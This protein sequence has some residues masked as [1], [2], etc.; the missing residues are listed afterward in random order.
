MRTPIERG[1][2]CRAVVHRPSMGGTP[3]DACPCN[4]SRWWHG[5]PEDDPFEQP[6][7]PPPT[8]DSI[9]AAAVVQSWW[10]NHLARWDD[11]DD[12]VTRVLEPYRL[13][14]P[15][16]EPAFGPYTTPALGFAAPRLRLLC[17]RGHLV[18]DVVVVREWDGDSSDERERWRIKSALKWSEAQ[19]SLGMGLRIAAPLQDKPMGPW[20][21]IGLRNR[22]R[23][24]NPK[25]KYDGRPKL[26]DLLR[27]YCLAVRTGVREVPLE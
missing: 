1:E 17:P 11:L 20:D 24:R 14:G 18:D 3:T 6:A 9:T 12:E 5:T 25:C 27:L 13:H 26:E 15:G 8:S 19:Y 4:H 21:S 23:C 10:E 22:A 2:A 7:P 16:F